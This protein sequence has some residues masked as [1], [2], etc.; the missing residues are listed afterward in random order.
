MKRINPNYITS[1][2]LFVFA[3]LVCFFLMH[4]CLVL[5]LASM[6]LGE[7]TDGLD[8]KVARM[9]GRVSDFGKIYDPMCDSIF[10]MTIWMSFLALGWVSVYFVIFFF[11]RD[12]MVSYIRIWL[13]SQR[14]KIIL[15]ARMSGKIKAVAQATTQISIIVF[16]LFLSGNILEYIQPALVW[17]AAI[18]TLYSLLDYGISSYLRVFRARESSSC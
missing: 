6:I 14:E 13:A 5:A 15:A 8:G 2:R 12:I 10:H 4:G 11:A 16:H 18:V 9:N 7:I 3:P 1:L 17:L